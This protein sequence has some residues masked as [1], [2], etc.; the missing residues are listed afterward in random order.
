MRDGSGLDLDWRPVMDDAPKLFN[1]LVGHHD[2]AVGPVVIAVRGAK[3]G[4]LGGE[5]VNH[6]VTARFHTQSG[7]AGPVGRDGIRDP[8]CQVITTIRLST[9]DIKK[10]FGC[11]VV[12]NPLLIADRTASQRV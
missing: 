2:A 10:T 1:F 9:L 6:D 11:A 5:T 3:R 4:L 8:Q 7:R 12:T